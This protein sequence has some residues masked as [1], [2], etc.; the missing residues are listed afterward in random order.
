MKSEELNSVAD[1]G[2][3]IVS[4]FKKKEKPLNVN[5]YTHRVKFINQV[6]N[7]QKATA[8]TVLKDKLETK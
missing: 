7:L 1:I 8:N 4:L 6:K 2:K 3:Y 5:N